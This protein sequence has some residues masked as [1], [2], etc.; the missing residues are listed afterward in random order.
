MHSAPSVIYPVGRSR[1][2][3]RLLLAL[4]AVGVCTVLSAS[5]QSTR[6]DWR[7]G[8]LLLCA[9]VATIAA[10]VGIFRTESR[11]NLIFDGQ[12]WSMSGGM[13]VPTAQAAVML[14]LQRLLLVRVKEPL[15]AARWIWLDRNAMPHLWR[16]LR[17]ALYSRAILTEVVARGPG[18]V[19]SNAHH[20][21]P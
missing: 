11:A 19:S 20:P 7:V 15:G 2:A 17:R 14:D 6:V 8:V 3:G 18:S 13:E 9:I 10:C 4:W 21:S 5:I 12:S 16:D 1:N